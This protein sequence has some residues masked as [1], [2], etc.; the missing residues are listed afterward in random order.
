ME[1]VINFLIFV[2]M[3]QEHTTALKEE[4]PILYGSNK[5]FDCGDGWFPLLREL[6]RHIEEY[7][8]KEVGEGRHVVVMQVKEK[9]GGL[10]FYVN[11]STTNIDRLIA[12]AEDRS[13]KV[14]ETCGEDGELRKEGWWKTLCDGCHKKKLER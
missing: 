10:R 4:C 13:F 7:N 14:C 2:P 6:S 5:Y 8:R 12:E 3:K 11:S 9:F 1:L